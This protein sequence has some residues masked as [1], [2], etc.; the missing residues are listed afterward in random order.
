MKKTFWFDV[1]T[2][3][4]SFKDS[5][6]LQ[7][8]AL[9]DVDGKIVQEFSINMQPH[10]DAIITP[11]ALRVHG[12][13]HVQWER[14]DMP[15]VGLHK[16][17]GV[18]SKYVDKYNTKDKFVVAGYNVGFDIQMLRAAFTRD[19]DKFF[20]SWFFWPVIDVQT[21]VAEEIAIFNLSL[22]NYKLGTVCKHFNIDI[23]AHEALSDIKATRNLYKKLKGA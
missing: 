19:G 18:L 1:E 9:I 10:E 13:T 17:R 15:D 7:L 12:I 5:A 20:G 3:G 2:T 14:Y 8:A 23:K 6:I 11:A 16:L 21:Y 22:T 4:V